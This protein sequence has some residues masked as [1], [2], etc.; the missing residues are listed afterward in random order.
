MTTPT[1]AA[2]RGPGDLDPNDLPTV[3]RLPRWLKPANRVIELL[4]RLGLAFFTFHLLSVPGRKT[5]RMRTTPVSPLFLE[6]RCYIVSIGQTEWVKNARVSGWASW[7]AAAGARGSICWSL[8]SKSGSRSFG[9]S[10]SSFPV[11]SRFW[12]GWAP[13]SRPATPMPS[14][15]PLRCWPC[16]RPR[17][18]ERPCD[19]HGE[20]PELGRGTGGASLTTGV[21]RCPWMS[22]EGQM[23]NK[24]GRPEDDEGDSWHLSGVVPSPSEGS[25]EER[26]ANAATVLAKSC[27][28]CA[29][30]C[31]R[32]EC[33]DF[34]T[35]GS[36]GKW[37][38]LRGRMGRHGR[39]TAAV[40]APVLPQVPG[41]GVSEALT[42]SAGVPT[43]AC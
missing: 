41:G 5:G 19:L 18:P 23:A 14:K 30:R 38:L 33:V 32:S 1:P 28:R 13:F 7:L 34:R 27:P 4:Q 16:S 25:D 26:A 21:D 29:K 6:N 36:E 31:N 35:G 3:R 42:A 39:S 20:A 43:T 40:G 8:G 11:V 12:C 24:G 2:M 15:R 9:S 17:P 22:W 10:L 37:R